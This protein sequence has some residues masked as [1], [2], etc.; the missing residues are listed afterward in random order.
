MTPEEIG[1]VV[2]T[3]HRFGRKVTAHSGSPQATRVAVDAGIDCI[4]HGYFLD[5]ETLRA[6]KTKGTWFVPTIVVSQPATRP[7]FERIGSPPWYLARL[8]SVG[9]DHWKALQMAIEEGVSIALGTDQFPHEEN[10][11]T[12]ATIREAQHY[13]DAGMTPLQALRA[14]TIE[15]AKLLEAS[16][17]VGSLEVGKFADLLAVAR[18]P[19]EDIKALREIQL[20][21]KGGTIY[22][23]ELRASRPTTSN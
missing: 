11:G 14:A 21:M 4:E 3:A 7:F 16:K 1:A 12:T 13:V 15:P 6:M 17:D 19:T 20:V 8:E 2:D 22:R 5:R 18:D 23:N 9:K 10:D